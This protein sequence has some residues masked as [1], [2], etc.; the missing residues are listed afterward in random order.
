MKPFQLLT[1]STVMTRVPFGTQRTPS[2][3]RYTFPD[4]ETFYTTGL[5]EQ[6]IEKGFKPIVISSR[7][8]TGDH[9]E[10]W[11]KMVREAGGEVVVM[12]DRAGGGG[13]AFTEFC[14]EKLKELTGEDWPTTTYGSAES[15]SLM[16]WTS[17]FDTINDKQRAAA[18]ADG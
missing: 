6:F 8:R 15:P 2:N 11:M 17:A 13:T 16:F 9:D 12:G 3:V 10:W 5:L 14:A 4:G 7:R 1:T 18:V